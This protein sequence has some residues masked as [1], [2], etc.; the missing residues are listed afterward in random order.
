[1]KLHLMRNTLEYKFLIPLRE[2]R[3]LLVILMRILVASTM[4]AVKTRPDSL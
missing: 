3:R 2:K 4:P 1:M